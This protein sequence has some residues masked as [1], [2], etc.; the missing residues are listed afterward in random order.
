MLRLNIVLLTLALFSGAANALYDPKPEEALYASQGEWR[1]A[2]TYKDYSQPDKSV[3]LP[4]TLFVALSGPNELV[5]NFVFNDGPGKTVYSYEKMSFD[6]KAKQVSWIS[7][8]A[9]RSEILAKI[10]SDDRDGQIRRIVFEK[11][12]NGEKE[13]FTLE[14]DAQHFTLQKEEI[15]AVGNT[16]LRNRF[17]F[18]RASA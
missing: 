15:P 13:R 9:E 7:G 5:L 14:L 2:L 16:V 6:F 8:I 10:T 12:S 17:A 3:T 11:E 1:G 4:T 18:K